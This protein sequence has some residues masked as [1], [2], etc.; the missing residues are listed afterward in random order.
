M[1]LWVALLVFFLIAFLVTKAM[2]RRRDVRYRAQHGGGSGSGEGGGGAGDGR[3]GRGWGDGGG[4][5][6]DGGGGGRE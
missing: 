1:W 4:D 5:W 2:G 6:G 3:G